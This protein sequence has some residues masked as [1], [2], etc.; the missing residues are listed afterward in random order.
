MG[1]NNKSDGEFKIGGEVLGGK[2]VIDFS[3]GDGFISELLSGFGLESDFDVGIGFSSKDG[4][5]FYGSSTLEIQLPTHIEIGPI[6]LSA[7]TLSVG[8]EGSKFPIRITSNIKAALGPLVA[9]VEQMGI[10]ADLSF[11]N[12]R[13]GN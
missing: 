1:T 5:F 13:S 2:I 9:S 6:E 7:L 11:P 3:Q 4:V 12:D 10:K 8:M